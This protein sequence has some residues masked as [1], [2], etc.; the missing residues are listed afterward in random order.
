M[1]EVFHG[2]QEPLNRSV[3]IK[4]LLPERKDDEEAIERFRREALALATL[5]HENIPAV[6]DLVEKYGRL[7]LIMEYV[8]GVDLAQ[9][10]ETGPIPLDVGL[11]IGSELAGALEHAHFRRVLHRDIKPSNVMLSR[12]GQV[13]LTDFG[14][15]KDQ[16]LDDMTRQGFVV[17]TL[18]YLSPE[19][20][21]GLR[22][23]WRSDIYGLGVT[24][25]ETLSG[26]R[27]H[28]E[29]PEQAELL[30]NI[31]GGQLRRLRQVAPH[32]P[33]SVEKVVH[34]CLTLDPAK[35]YQRAA[36]VRRA[37][38]RL[39]GAVLKGTRSARVVG[40]LKERKL[41]DGQEAT[42]IA[43]DEV[44]AVQTVPKPETVL[45]SR[46]FERPEGEASGGL[47]RT[48]VGVL[49]ALVLVAGGLAAAWYLAPDWSRQTLASLATWGQE[50][51]GAQTDGPASPPGG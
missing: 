36:E 37:L 44:E 2:F 20:I 14:I 15:A 43:S 31:L 13:M 48:L 35:R 1:A 4:A 49:L 19:Q 21:G 26:Q 50:R 33:R 51:V 40:F 12:T 22:A 5:H 24:L 41:L 25:F 3:A 6:H 27:P 17:G 23:D 8:D 10:L 42:L 9:V 47:A 7:Y 28:V 34:R 46:H 32:L 18:N 39:L 11:L 16:N 38:D 29:G 30:A 45:S